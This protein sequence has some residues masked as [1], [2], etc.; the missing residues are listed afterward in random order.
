MIEH[1]VTQG[2]PQ[3][4]KLRRGI[5]TGSEFSRI[6]NATKGPIEVPKEQVPS[7]LDSGEFNGMRLTE[8][9]RAELIAD[10]DPKSRKQYC[11]FADYRL[12]T[13]R[14]SYIAELIAASCGW[15]PSFQGS[16]D[17]E[18]G[19]LLERFAAD[20]FQFRHG[21]KLREVG[22]ITSDCGRYGASPDRMTEDGIPVEIKC[23]SL[24]TFIKW[25]MDLDDNGQPK[26]PQDHKAQLHGEMLVTGADRAIFI[27]YADSE[28]I[29]NFTL[30]VERDEFTER[31]REHLETFCAELDEWRRKLTGEE[32]EI[33]F[34]A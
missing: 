21:K 12:A 32:Y 9:N 17:T 16:P 26:L 13:G 6:I 25:R 30:T 18:R 19:N 15:I 23:P 29:D 34:G 7:V 2:S 33:L 10:F 1:N 24:H 11:R 27:A 5:P 28:Y 4:Y 20:W 22:F 3:W 31:L 14:E 8:S